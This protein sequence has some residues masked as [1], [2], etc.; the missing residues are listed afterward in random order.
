MWVIGAPSA[1]AITSGTRSRRGAEHA[2]E[3]EH[4]RKENNAHASDDELARM[5]SGIK[6]ERGHLRRIAS[7]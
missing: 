1:C 6:R 3:H 5:R 4:E 7:R 2:H